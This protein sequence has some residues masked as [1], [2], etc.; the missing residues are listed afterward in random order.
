[1]GHANGKDHPDLEQCFD[2]DG[3]VHYARMA[4]A[5]CVPYQD[6]RTGR[7]PLGY[8]YFPNGAPTNYPEFVHNHF[9]LVLY[10]FYKPKVVCDYDNGYVRQHGFSD[11][12]CGCDSSR[13]YLHIQWADSLMSL[14]C[15]KCEGPSYQ[16][17]NA[18]AGVERHCTCAPNYF[19]QAPDNILCHLLIPVIPS[20][21]GSYKNVLFQILAI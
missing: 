4:P 15:V 13:N 9:P 11:T 1:M 8:K 18:S 17:V 21:P 10:N 7:T 20:N 14:A 19:L 6:S 3:S 5:F 16:I 2:C 12:V